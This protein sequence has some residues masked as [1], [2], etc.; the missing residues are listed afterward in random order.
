ME[1]PCVREMRRVQGW[2]ILG[3]LANGVFL[4]LDTPSANICAPS[5]QGLVLAAGGATDSVMTPPGLSS[6]RPNPV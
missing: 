5:M 2:G 4:L 6:G 1:L 3:D